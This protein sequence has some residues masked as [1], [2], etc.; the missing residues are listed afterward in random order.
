MGVYR[1]L[2]RT[3][4]GIAQASCCLTALVF[5]SCSNEAPSVS[6]PMP[7]A[8]KL[9]ITGVTVV[10]TQDGSLQPDMNILLDGGKIASI[11]SSAFLPNPSIR[12][13]D[14]RGKFVIPGFLDM[15]A[16]LL[17]PQ[18]SRDMLMLLLSNGITG[19]R[20]MSGDSELLKERREGALPLSGVQPEL[21]AMPGEIL[22]P[23][24]AG[25]PAR[26]VAAVQRQKTEGADFIKVILVSSPAFFAAQREAKRLNLP[27]VGHLP[28]GVDVIAASKGGMKSIEHMG[29]G[30]DLLIPCSTDASTLRAAIDR[31]PPFE[32]FGIKLLFLIPFKSALMNWAAPKITTNTTSIIGAPEMAKFRQIIDTFSAEKCRQLAAQFVADGTWQDPTLI[33]EK[34]SQQAD[35]AEFLEDPNLRYIPAAEVQSWRD[36]EQKYEK[37]FSAAEKQTFRDWYALHLKVVKLFDEAGVKL[38]IGDDAGG[39]GWVVPGFALHREFD[40]FAKAG[41]SPLHVLQDATLNGAEFLGRTATLGRVALGNNADL[42][43][44]DANPIE[45]VQNLHKIYAVVRAGHYLSRQELDK[46]QTEVAARQVAKQ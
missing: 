40:E 45:S 1:S 29:A 16:H 8:D 4:G 37:K 3:I 12:R 31:S 20:Q 26:A 46:M 19:W 27:F 15:H 43:L 11:Q 42:V 22:T 5:S 10:N 9:L 13:I 39:A 14:A 21:L 17:A 30:R 38:L 2:Y 6:G 34:S 24:N 35:A 25:T 33:R 23:L 36:S 41:I 28:T 18:N 32:S 44:L 7:K